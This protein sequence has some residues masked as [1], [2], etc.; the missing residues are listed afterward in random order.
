MKAIVS[1]NVAYIIGRVSTW[2]G[3]RAIVLQY[4]VE[5]DIYDPNFS[6]TLDVYYDGVIPSSGERSGL[7]PNAQF[8]E[9]SHLNDKDRFILKDMPIRISYKECGQVDEVISALSGDKWL[10]M[11][12]GTY[13]F[14]RIATGTVEW[15]RDKWINEVR[16]KLDN[17]PDS[18][19]NF[20]IESC[21]HRIDHFLGDMRASA[22]K[23]DA[24]YFHLSLGDFL[25]ASVKLL[26]AVNNVFEPGPRDYTAS[27][28]LLEIIPEGFEAN[29]KSLLREDAELPPERKREL[30]EL[31]TRS[32]LELNP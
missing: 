13:L 16:T 29:W 21:R 3:V 4:F 25:R 30:A 17:L 12:R 15:T 24:L 31:L 26:F 19:W 5:K 23:D 8:F 18:F 32:L 27:L 11:E 1:Q 20:W 14:Y 9:T 22:I 2:S 28:A 7:F 6:I 10:S